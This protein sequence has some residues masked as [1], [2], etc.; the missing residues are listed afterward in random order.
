MLQFINIGKLAVPMYGLLTVFGVGLAVLVGY[1]RANIN[2]VRKD[3]AFYAALFA[4]VGLLIGA[5]LLYIITDFKSF[6]ALVRQVGVFKAVGA[7][8]TGFVFYGG[9]IGAA[10]GLLIYCRAFKAPLFPMLDTL[11]PGV[12]LAHGVGRIGCFCAGCCWGM[13]YDGPLAVVFPNNPISTAP[14]GVKLFPIQLFESG[15]NF[16]LFIGL[17]LLARRPRRRGIICGTYICAYS[18]AR[19]MFE[20]LRGDDLRGVFWGLSTSQIIS[21]VFFPVGAVLLIAGLRPSKSKQK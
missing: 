19:F 3:D 17:M 4:I 9:A 5:K 16:L 15:F 1:L 14:Y 6:S 12:P 7:S 11:V 18:A 10:A 21:A 20:F 2:G 8:R 13:R